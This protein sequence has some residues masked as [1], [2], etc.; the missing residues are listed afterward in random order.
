VSFDVKMS[1]NEDRNALSFA[2]CAVVEEDPVVDG[3]LVEEEGPDV[4][5]VLVVKVV[6]TGGE[7]MKSKD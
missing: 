3:I 4:D 1:C 2:D 7:A 5:G 6:G